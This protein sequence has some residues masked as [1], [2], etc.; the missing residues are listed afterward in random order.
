MGVDFVALADELRGL[1]TADQTRQLAELLVA[2]G[3][4]SPAKGVGTTS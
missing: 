1:L 2:H 4:K 3:V